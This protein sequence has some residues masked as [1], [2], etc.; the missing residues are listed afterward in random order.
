LPTE[1]VQ[2]MDSKGLLKRNFDKPLLKD[3]IVFPTHGYAIIR[4]IADNPGFWLFH[5]HFDTHS[6]NGMT[7]IF[8][9]GQDKDLPSKPDNWPTC[10]SFNKFQNEHQTSF[11]QSVANF[12]TNLFH[13]FF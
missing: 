10:G 5:C 12:L 1:L 13:M 11:L 2:E 3:T 4:F 7:L 8:K 9:V 6:D